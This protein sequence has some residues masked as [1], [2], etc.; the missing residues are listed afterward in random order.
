MVVV[1][2]SE[3]QGNSNKGREDLVTIF[4]RCRYFGEGGSMVTQ[5]WIIMVFGQFGFSVSGHTWGRSGVV[6]GGW[7]KHAVGFGSCSGVLHPSRFIY[8]LV[9]AYA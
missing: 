7:G 6:C 2:G 8:L 9:L 1:S 4:V 5:E 3:K